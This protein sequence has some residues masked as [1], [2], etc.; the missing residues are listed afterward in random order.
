MDAH[1]ELHE[2]LRTVRIIV[3]GIATGLA[4]FL[5]YVA[6]AHY[7]AGKEPTSADA[8]LLTWIGLAAALVSTLVFAA[9]R[10]RLMG[11]ARAAYSDGDIEG[12]R[13]KYTAG[14]IVGVAGIEGP[15]FLLCV[16]FMLEGQ[17]IAL[18][19]AAVCLLMILFATPTRTHVDHLLEMKR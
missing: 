4:A 10:A 6:W 7:G 19:G 5:A 1:P 15:G 9:L 3:L 11:T 18:A 14:V 12:F 13:Q 8:T 17:P 16:A 2:M